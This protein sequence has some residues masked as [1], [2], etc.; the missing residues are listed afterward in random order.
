MNK[1]GSIPRA[2]FD[3]K[4]S[5]DTQD[6]TN[7]VPNSRI[8]PYDAHWPIIFFGMDIARQLLP[9]IFPLEEYIARSHNHANMLTRVRIF[10]EERHA[11]RP[12]DSRGVADIM[13]EGGWP[14]GKLVM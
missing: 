9:K 1:L 12:P 7:A 6:N 13:S 3:V 11:P 2:P 4:P 5:G 8:A 10:N 14:R